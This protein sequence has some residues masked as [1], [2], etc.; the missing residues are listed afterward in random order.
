MKRIAFV[1]DEPLI[2]RAFA[3]LLRR[4]RH[5]WALH[6]I[7]S[8]ADVLAAHDADP[9]DVVVSDVRMPGIDGVTLVTRLAAG[10]SPPRCVLLSG[11]ADERLG[12]RVGA[13]CHRILAKPCRPQDLVSALE[14]LC[15]A[16]P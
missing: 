15:D 9:F 10:R 16:A 6:Y 12:E 14:S 7:D 2:L 1:D 4:E 8:G 5:R 3:S 13:C 11:D